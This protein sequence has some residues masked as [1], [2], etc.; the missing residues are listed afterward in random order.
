MTRLLEQAISKAR[1]ASAEQQNLVGQV[2]L[3]ILEADEKWEALLA[4]PRS[5][6]LL[7]QLADEARREI[8]QGKSLDTDP[9]CEPSGPPDT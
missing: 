3:D 4:D 6:T 7:S 8:A 1:K 9:S 5:E 2:V